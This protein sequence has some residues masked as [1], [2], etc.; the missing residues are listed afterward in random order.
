MELLRAHALLADH[1]V[2]LGYVARLLKLLVA[3]LPVKPQGWPSSK[4]LVKHCNTHCHV[5]GHMVYILLDVLF[6]LFSLDR[7]IVQGYPDGCQQILLRL[8]AA[9]MRAECGAQYSPESSSE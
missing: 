4:G 1:A 3:R 2:A 5:C 6:L 9:G 7:P 8:I